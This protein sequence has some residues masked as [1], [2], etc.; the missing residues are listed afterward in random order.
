MKIIASLFLTASCTLGAS[1]FALTP[2]DQYGT[3][4]T[5]QFAQRTIVVG[6]NTKYVN[7]KHGE[8]VT[9]RDGANSVNWYFD[10]VSGAFALSKILSAPDL[11]PNVTI[12]V[13]AEMIG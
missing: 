2:A 13:E 5:A 8:T 10:G 1:A 9:I 6:S 3:A 4:A 7:V 11:N 12:Y